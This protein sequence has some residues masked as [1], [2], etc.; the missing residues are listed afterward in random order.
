VS[1]T[2]A[3]DRLEIVEV[4][5]RDGLQNEGVLLATDDK[6]ELITA[7]IAA[8]ARRIEATSFV[9]PR[10]VP[11]MAD[12]EAVMAGVPR[13]DGVRFSGLVLNLRGL[14]RA[15]AAG[16]D[17][18]NCVVVSTETFSQRNQRMSVDEALEVVSGVIRE[19]EGTS[20]AVTVTLAVAFGCPFEGR[21]APAVVAGLARRVADLGVQEISLADTVGVGV[22]SQVRALAG[23]VREAAPQATLRCHFHNTRNTG[24]ANAVAAYESGIRV[25]D[26]SIGG[27][28]GC[29]FAPAATGNIATEDLVYLFDQM[30]VST[31]L[32]LGRLID[33]SRWLGDRLGAPTPALLPRAGGFPTAAQT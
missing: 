21:V 13:Q 3:A 27:I 11:Q 8:G 28:G 24:Y 10:L 16:V 31:G 26:S 14:E 20:I 32:D 6:L 17:E 4:G 29:P 22:P 25:L 15:V 9:H 5:P 12:A 30:G 19:V 33:A 1:A 18:V 7:S 23:L 2:I